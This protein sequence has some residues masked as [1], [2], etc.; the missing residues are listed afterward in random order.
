M[1]TVVLVIKCKQKKYVHSCSVLFSS[2]LQS[3]GWTHHGRTFSIYLCPLSFWLTLLRRVL[4][5]YWCCPSRPSVHGLPRLHAPGIV[6]CII[7]FSSNSFVSSWCLWPTHLF[8]FLSTKLAESFSALS[9]FKGVKTCFFIL[10]ATLVLSWVVSSLK[11]VCCDFSIIL[12]W[13]PNCLPLV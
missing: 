4:S 5:T 13:C 9:H 10:Q 11:S 12:Q 3:S 8:S 1:F 7:S 6:S 2:R